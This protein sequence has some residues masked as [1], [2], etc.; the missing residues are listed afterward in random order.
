MSVPLAVPAEEGDEKTG[1]GFFFPV[2]KSERS[3]AGSVDESVFGQVGDRVEGSVEL[4][5]RTVNILLSWNHK[6]VK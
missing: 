3:P 1:P 6:S 4:L 5:A 2:Q